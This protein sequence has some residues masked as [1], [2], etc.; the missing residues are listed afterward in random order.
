MGLEIIQ[1]SKSYKN[2]LA[3]E[4]I[5]LSLTPGVYALL[6]PNGAGKSTLINLLTG[7]LKPNTGSILYNG[8]DIEDLGKKYRSVLGF[9]PQQQGLYEQFSGYRFLNYMAALKGMDAITTKSEIDRVL[10]LVNLQD[11]ANRLL[12]QYSGGMKQRILIAQAIMNQPDFI[13]LDEPTAG[14]DPKER[15]RIRNIIS[16][17]AGEKIVLFATHVVSDIEHIAKEVILIKKGNIL[18]H[19]SPLE[20][21]QSMQGKVFEVFAQEN[22]LEELQSTFLVSNIFQQADGLVVRIVSDQKPE[23]YSYKEVIPNLEDVYLYH[24]NDGL[25]GE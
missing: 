13:I 24:F 22:Q 16:K 5:N 19:H 25:M 18:D 1:L 21:C 12:S 11:E 15:I 23:H 7:N 6:G 2:F 4:E 14:L 20:F 17:I 10:K 8:K 3:L 9:M